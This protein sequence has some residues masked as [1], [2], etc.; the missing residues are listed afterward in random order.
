MRPARPRQQRMQIAELHRWPAPNADA[1]G[2]VP[3]RD[4]AP[5]SPVQQLHTRSQGV[6]AE[7]FQLFLEVFL[8]RSEELGQEAF[9]A[10][11]AAC[12]LI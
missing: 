10:T 4:F 12:T 6:E 7:F 3:G 11:V 2:R 9:F 1:S 5:H 8:N